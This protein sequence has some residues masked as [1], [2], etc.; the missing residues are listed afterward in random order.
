MKRF[1]PFFLLL[2]TLPTFAQQDSLTIFQKMY[3]TPKIADKKAVWLTLTHD[4]QVAVRRLNF[5]WGIG[6]L[7]LNTVQVDYLTRFSAV[8]PTIERTELNTW[9]TEALQLFPVEIGRLLFGSI[10][11]FT[12]RCE[13]ALQKV[14]RQPNNCPCSVGSIFNM[15]CDGDCTAANGRCTVLTEGCGFAWLYACNGFCSPS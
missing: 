1:A 13:L 10:G 9:Q 11:P 2:L 12:D 8:L 6:A 4:E 15:S 14:S 5:A 7:H 3:D